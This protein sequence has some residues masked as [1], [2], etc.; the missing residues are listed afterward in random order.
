M[1]LQFLPPVFSVVH[2]FPHA[3]SGS[4]YLGLFGNPDSRVVFKLEVILF[5]MDKDICMECMGDGEFPD[6][7]EISDKKIQLLKNVSWQLITLD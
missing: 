5:D 2:N 1:G 3:E 7:L 6:Y 4:V